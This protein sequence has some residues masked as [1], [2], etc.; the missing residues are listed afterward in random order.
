MSGVEAVAAAWVLEQDDPTVLPLDG[1]YA[2]PVPEGEARA[3]LER[4][5]PAG[6][7]LAW[8]ARLAEVIARAAL[9]RPWEAAWMNLRALAPDGR[10]EAL[11]ELVRGQLL[12][13]RRLRAGLAHLETGFRLAVPHLDARG[14]LVLL[15]RHE[16]LARLPLGE[17]S[18][19]PAPLAALLAEAGVA[20]RLRGRPVAGGAAAPDPCDTVG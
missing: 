18:R 8:Q 2:E 17:R 10:A 13:A 1:W 15:R 11:A 5:G 4:L 6:P 19:A 12:V 14:Y 20:A 3:L 16:R 7:G 9:E